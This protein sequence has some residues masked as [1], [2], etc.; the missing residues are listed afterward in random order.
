M[1]KV[2]IFIPRVR[3]QI[4]KIVVIE[5]LKRKL[6]IWSRSLGIKYPKPWDKILEFI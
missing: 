5:N 4:P 2:P 1:L 6:E 3:D